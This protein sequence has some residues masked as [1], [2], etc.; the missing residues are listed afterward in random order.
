MGLMNKEQYQRL[1][2]FLLRRGSRNKMILYLF[3][4]GYSVPELV[5]FTVNDF[6]EL[7][8]PED[9]AI[10]RDEVLDL[11]PDTTPTSPVFVFQGGRR[12]T[13][14]DFYRIVKQAA[15]KTINQPMSRQQFLEYIQT[16]KK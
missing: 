10:L 7:D 14:T 12:M 3:A 8:L 16:G 5:K 13:H 11:M 9:I 15:E 1:E 2:P 6:N 4:C